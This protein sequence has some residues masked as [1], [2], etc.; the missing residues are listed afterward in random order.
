MSD[1]KPRRFTD[2]GLLGFDLLG[3]EEA[4][5]RARNVGGWLD[6]FTMGG[7]LRRARGGFN[8]AG[9]IFGGLLSGEGLPD[10]ERLDEVMEESVQRDIPFIDS[11]NL[12]KA[13]RDAGSDER[14]TT[15]GGVL[16]GAIDS[17]SMGV[18]GLVNPEWS[19]VMSAM[20]AQDAGTSVGEKVVNSAQAA[21]GAGTGVARTVARSAARRAAR[22]RAGDATALLAERVGRIESRPGTIGRIL[23]SKAT[24]GA[25]GVGAAAG[26][27]VAASDPFD[28]GKAPHEAELT[29]ERGVA[30][31]VS[32]EE[33]FG[34]SPVT[35]AEEAFGYAPPGEG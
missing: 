9:E 2:G 22:D 23:G 3:N 13:I 33:A 17:G 28:L 11:T 27:P 14:P 15:L 8:Q 25:V 10:R 4:R 34:Q 21:A 1:P 6:Q 5:T 31:A 35:S 18:G 30:P 29:D 32:L 26:V 16:A 7:A 12:S 20:R 19:D 24:R